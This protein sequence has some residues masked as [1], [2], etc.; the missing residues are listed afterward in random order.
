MKVR[1]RSRI[2]RVGA[3]SATIGF[4]LTIAGSSFASNQQGRKSISFVPVVA[5]ISDSLQ[6]PEDLQRSFA[7]AQRSA[8]ESM[9]RWDINPLPASFIDTYA[10]RAEANPRNVADLRNALSQTLIPRIQSILEL[11][12]LQRAEQYIDEADRRQFISEKAKELSLTESDI[13]QVMNSAFIAVPFISFLSEKRTEEK[14]S[15]ELVPG[16]AWYHVKK[17]ESGRLK[18][19]HLADVGLPQ[20]TS[21][22][23]KKTVFDRKTLQ[24]R[25][26]TL[27]Y[28]Q[29]RYNAIK[30]GL[31]D[32]TPF[33]IAQTK[34]LPPF[35]LKTTIAAV[36]GRRIE[37]SLGSGDDVDLDDMY[38]LAEYHLND[39]GKPILKRVGFARVSSVGNSR[40]GR[41]TYA[42]VI[43]T[44]AVL[45]PGITLLERPGVGIS[46]TMGAGIKVLK[47]ASGRIVHGGREYYNLPD[48]GDVYLPTLNLGLSQNLA[49]STGISQLFL[50]LD[51][52]G[53]LHKF[54]SARAVS[55]EYKVGMDI[56]IGASATLSKKYWVRA[57][58]L[59]LEAGAGAMLWQNHTKL[60]DSTEADVAV[61]EYRQ[62]AVGALVGAT[63]EL[64]KKMGKSIGLS[65]NYWFGVPMDDWKL[66]IRRPDEKNGSVVRPSNPDLPS[67]DMTGID[68]RAYVLYF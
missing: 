33:I 2:C 14:V 24:Q 27:S 46:L 68:V 42:S 1:P 35:S 49:K 53:S 20:A 62:I 39:D 11:N 21:E 65:V 30:K 50:N 16:V 41:A 31:E 48:S 34:A 22:K 55:G 28:S 60:D 44:K 8:L 9:G 64:A 7:A 10:K 25:R 12:A 56:I 52:F 3:I 18:A 47:F 45:V 61:L 43:R 40:T 29:A 59:E 32:V 13:R 5:V 67:I 38:H 37:F 4:I 63:L 58:A 26:V 23:F 57:V 17:D 51:A 66:E 19:E 6:I 54:G 36:K 15:V